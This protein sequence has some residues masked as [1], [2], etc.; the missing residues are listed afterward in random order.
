MSED[1][2]PDPEI[3]KQA[4]EEAKNRR[5]KLDETHARLKEEKEYKGRG[6]PDPVRYGDWESKGRAYDF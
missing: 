6:G 1:K 2:R 5:E 4:L 3:A